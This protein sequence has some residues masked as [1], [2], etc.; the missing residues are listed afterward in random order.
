MSISTQKKMLKDYAKRNG[1]LDCQ[2]YVDDGYSG[3][4]YDRLLS[5]SLLR[6][7]RTGKLSTLITKKLSRLGRN[8]L[9]TGT[10]IKVFLMYITLL[11]MTAWTP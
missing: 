2:F 3:T 4:N 6:T 1:F 10:Y 7:Y 8:Y 5:D 9:E 11:S